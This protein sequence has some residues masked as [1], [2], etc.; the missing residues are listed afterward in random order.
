MEIDKDF[1]IKIKKGEGITYALKR[2]VEEMPNSI[3][4]DDKFTVS[5]WNATMDKLIELNEKRKA[6]GKESIFTG[7]T[8]KTRNGWNNSFIVHPDQEIVFSESE[9]NELF[10]AMGVTISKNS[11]QQQEEVKSGEQVGIADENKTSEVEK[12]DKKERL[13]WKEIGKIAWKSTKKFDKGM[14]CDE[15]GKF[16][17]GRTAATVGIIVGLTLAAPAVAALGASAAVVGAVATTVKIAGVALTGYM[18]YNG[19]KN[20]IKG[21]KDYYNAET[22]EDA[23]E[24]MEQAWDGGVELASIPVIG[25]LMKA[26]GKLLKLVKPKSSAPKNSTGANE[27]ANQG[28]NT[29]PKPVEPVQT[30]VKPVEVVNEGGTVQPKPVE[31]KPVEGVNEGV[32]PSSN[33]Q[34]KPSEVTPVES[35]VENTPTSQSSVTEPKPATNKKERGF[36]EQMRRDA[37]AQRIKN[38]RKAEQVRKAEEARKAQE[39]EQARRAEEARKA[40]EAEQVRKAEEARKAQEAEARKAEEAQKAQEAERAR[41]AEE[42]LNTQEAEQASAQLVQDASMADTKPATHKKERGFI[43]Q[44]SRD[45]KARRIK[46]ERKAEQARMAEEARKAQEAEARKAQEAEDARWA[47]ELRKVEEAKKL[48]R[49]TAEP[50]ISNETIIPEGGINSSEIGVGLYDMG[51][52]G[53]RMLDPRELIKKHYHDKNIESPIIGVKPAVFYSKT[54]NTTAIVC[55]GIGGGN[56]WGCSMFTIKGKISQEVATDLIKYLCDKKLL[57]RFNKW[58]NKVTGGVT[59]LSEELFQKAIAEFFNNRY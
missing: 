2:L 10:T 40:Q 6:E 54:A 3:I 17:L 18:L 19:G 46:N 5:E 11:A 52:H 35:P 25:G 33:I 58:E 39:A 32:N 13:S 1:K 20:V 23:V 51:Y 14:F 26:G 42:A 30:E 53:K 45:A 56:G 50:Y 21:T 7:G 29:Q 55:N 47:E 16:S 36:V 22:K 37:K 4:S 59:P 44:M 12:Y 15:E 41:N 57:T 34:P 43:E 31:V 9:I 8:D 48:L 28:S 27:G 38:E 24:A 49:E